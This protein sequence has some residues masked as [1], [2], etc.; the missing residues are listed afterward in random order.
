MHGFTGGIVAW[1]AVEHPG[2]LACTVGGVVLGWFLFAA[3]DR[4]PDCAERE[5]KQL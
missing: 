2:A 3:L 4:C 5:E 1:L